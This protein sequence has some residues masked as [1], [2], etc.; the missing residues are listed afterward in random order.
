MELP[1]CRPS[2][3]KGKSEC[4]TRSCAK[5]AAILRDDERGDLSTYLAQ[6]ILALAALTQCNRNVGHRRRWPDSHNRR[7][8]VSDTSHYCVLGV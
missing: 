5:L 6:G 2:A 4:G 8:A 1:S 3:R 7:R